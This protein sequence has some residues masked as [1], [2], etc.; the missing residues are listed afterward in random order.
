MENRM[1]K[2]S[3]IESIKGIGEKTAKLFSKLHIS[4]VDELLRHYPVSY[5][6]FERPI[7]IC[8]LKEG[9]RVSFTAHLYGG[10]ATKKVRSLVI[11]NLKVRDDSGEIALTFFHMPYL[12]S[13]LKPGC[14]H[15]FRGLVQKRGNYLFV[16][17]PAIYKPEEYNLL[18]QALQPRYALT[19]GLTNKT[20]TKAVRNILSGPSG[21]ATCE[22]LPQEILDK[23]KLLSR[24]DALSQ[25]HF[26][27]DYASL[28][29]AHKRLAYEEFYDF[30]RL[31]RSCREQS[32]GEP[33]AYR[34]FET[35][36]TVRLLEALP[37]TL[38]AAQ[39]KVWA[40]IRDD[41]SGEYTMNRLIQGDVGSGKT[42][43]A[44]LSL[45][46]TV[47]NGFQG[48]LMAPTDVLASQHFE[49]ISRMTKEYGLAFKPVLLTGSV[50]AAQKR[51]LYE[52]IA[53]GEANLIIGTHALIQEKVSYKNLALVVTDEQ[54]RFGVKQRGA[55]TDKGV[56][57]HVLV[58]SA[59][60][61]PRTLAIILYGDLKI[62]VIDERPANRLPI[63]N[64][65][66]GITDRDKSYRFIEKEV[67][68]GRQ[69]YVI[70]PMVEEGE[71]S[72]LEN[73]IDYAERLKRTFS[74][75]LQVAYLHGRMKPA[76]KNKIMTAFAA[77]DID[78]LVS[79]TVIEVGIDVA[80]AT[81]MM[82]ENAER[83]GLAQL[84]QLRGR[85]GR[86][87][88]QSYCIFLNTS[89]SE[90]AKAR[91]SVLAN[92]NDGFQIAAEDLKMRGP[93]DLFGIRQSGILSFSMADIYQDADMLS[94]AQEDVE[95]S[96]M[97]TLPNAVST[98]L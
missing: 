19:A 37:Y 95:S 41:V 97:L 91:L 40:Q 36:D 12:K 26:P 62:S 58:M 76:E 38:T 17:Q 34:L 86:G 46:M 63:K 89:D 52:K 70:C 79:T 35:A 23:R 24:R 55:L 74:S 59:T 71:S 78:V 82:I 39:K 81:V 21:D 25:I 85:V 28:A 13:I 2:D 6:S 94:A 77:G 48:A 16:E 60:P 73:V 27:R 88:Y 32:L 56:H 65:V 18:M 51:K 54:H 80:N 1:Q 49:T 14:D 75:D 7:R 61:I 67:K 33:N 92:S 98:I 83:F 20:V 10:I 4:N 87:A 93:G 53:S 5:D 69:A 96:S 50:S 31:L 57:V 68:S 22:T 30:L 44:I 47:A 72:D 42:I 64:A 29:A 9:A 11:S 90:E 66:V 84:H 15:V 8:D 45:L 43:I 3:S